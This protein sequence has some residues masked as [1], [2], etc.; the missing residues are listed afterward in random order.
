M[1]GF[2]IYV[3]S[4]NTFVHP[5][6]AALGPLIVSPSLTSICVNG[7]ATAG[8]CTVGTANGAGVVEVTTIE[9]TGV[10]ECGGISPCSGLAF[11]ITYSVVGATPSTSLSYPSAAGCANTSVVGTTTCVL[12]A[13]SIGTTLPET[14]QGATVAIALPNA[15]VCITYPSTMT[16]CSTGPAM[17]SPVNPGQTFTVGVRVEGSQPFAGFDIYVS[18]DSNYLHPQSAALGPGIASPS[19]TS[20]CVN[21]SA[22]NGTCTVGTANG[23]G[24]VE[25]STVESSGS[26]ECAAAPCSGLLFTIT[27]LDVHPTPSTLIHLGPT[28]A[29]CGNSSVSSPSNVCVLV[30]NAVG[31]SVPESTQDAFAKHPFFKNTTSGAVICTP[32]PVG[33]GL[34]DN[35]SPTICIATIPDTNSTGRVSPIGKVTFTT[36]GIGV[37]NPNM[38]DLS[39]NGT[40]TVSSC[41]VPYNP[42]QVGIGTH[43]IGCIYLGD[44]VHSGST[45]SPFKLIISPAAV[46]ISTVV[47]VDLTGLP[48][49]ATV[50]PAQ[51]LLLHDQA[52]MFHG[53]Q[54]T[55]VIGTVTYTLYPNSLCTAGTGTVVSTVTVGPADNVPPSG[56]VAPAAGSWSFDATFN[57]VTT[58]NV[59]VRSGCEPFLVAQAPGFTAG[60]LHWTH[61]L[62]LSKSL[63]TQ[64]WTAIVTNPLSV[65]AK[66][67]VRI[68]GASTINPSLSF[69]ITCG[70]TCVSTA[71]GGVSLTPGLTPV[72]VAAGTSST[73]FTFN[74]LISGSFVNQKFAFTATVYWTTGTLYTASDSK[75]GSFAVVP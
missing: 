26:N 36:D 42:D 63:N 7:A 60:K 10:N 39:Q 49:N 38:C 52:I 64:S 33:V 5:V 29:G 59:A 53:W 54:L 65:T 57:P 30:A 12:V 14:I 68:V 46:T 71:T 62:S 4:D 3:K 44:T 22:Q 45:C 28:G 8:A 48:F 13:D 74:Q 55:G 18:V 72:S 73:S 19:L 17:I 66:L 69:D 15:V 20:I 34:T 16:P 56:P 75:S 40:T 21:G 58:N 70:V 67:V 50:P 6:S 1:G 51:G 35:S 2:D 61:H 43:L 31:T 23:N 32:N 37:F 24:V 11:T 41:G 27:Y 9:G 47:I 25:V